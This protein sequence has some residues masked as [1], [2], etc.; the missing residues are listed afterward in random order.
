MGELKGMKS[1]IPLEKEKEKG[2][3]GNEKITI[4]ICNILVKTFLL[5]F[6]FV[7]LIEKQKRRK[8]RG[9]EGKRRGGTRKGEINARKGN[10]E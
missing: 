6:L 3:G 10:G 9:R 2:V 8:T 4:S 1:F 7:W 5:F